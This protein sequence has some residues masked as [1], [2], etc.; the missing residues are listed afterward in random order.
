MA[1]HSIALL[2]SS[3][4]PFLLPSSS[5]ASHFSPKPSS[6]SNPVLSQCHH[7]IVI[8]SFGDSNSNTLN[9]LSSSASH[10]ISPMAVP[11]SADQLV[12]SPMNASIFS[13]SHRTRPLL[14][15][16]IS[17]SSVGGGR[18]ALQEEG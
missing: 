11:F 15:I 17:S 14:W 5:M 10:S 18:M 16:L 3:S 7:T 6:L 8:F 4:S 13:V 12:V 9:S 1:S 2:S